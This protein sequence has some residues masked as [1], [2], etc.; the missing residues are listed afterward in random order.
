MLRTASRVVS[1]L[2]TSFLVVVI[3]SAPADEIRGIIDAAA[4]DILRLSRIGAKGTG[5]IDHI[6]RHVRSDDSIRRDSALDPVL[7]GPEHIEIVRTRTTT[8][9]V[10]AG[11][12]EESGEL[13]RILTESIDYVREFSY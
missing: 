4:A 5:A 7:Q 13:Q 12:H 1:S 6:P 11:R 3:Q 2:H 8:A 10:Y 9:M